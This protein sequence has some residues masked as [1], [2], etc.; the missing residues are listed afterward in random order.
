MSAQYL[1]SCSHKEG[2]VSVW[3]MY[4]S[5]CDEQ[6]EVFPFNRS[7]PMKTFLHEDVTSVI[8][9]PGRSN[10]F[11]SFS[12]ER[13]TVYILDIQARGEKSIRA[14]CKT[15]S[16]KGKGINKD[17]LLGIEFNAARPNRFFSYSEKGII[18]VLD[19]DS[20][21]ELKAVKHS[22]VSQVLWKP[23]SPNVFVSF[24]PKKGEIKVWDVRSKRKKPILT[25]RDRGSSFIEFVPGNS[26]QLLSYPDKEKKTETKF[27]DISG[28][29]VR[30]LKTFNE[31]IGGFIP[32]EPNR[33]YSYSANDCT[34]RIWDIRRLD[35]EVKTF[36]FCFPVGSITFNS[37][38]PHLFVTSFKKKGMILLWDI[39][40][41]D[42]Q[43]PKMYFDQFVI[44]F[45]A[46]KLFT[47]SY[48]KSFL[49]V[50]VYNIDTD[51]MGEIKTS[52]H[53]YADWDI[54]NSPEFSEV[55]ASCSEKEGMIDAWYVDDFDLKRFN[56]F[57]HCGVSSIAFQ[58]VEPEKRERIRLETT[59]SE[60]EQERIGFL[61]QRLKEG[62]RQGEEVHVIPAG[63]TVLKGFL[64][65]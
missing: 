43:E 36:K 11:A 38:R 51:C 42:N 44:A 33:Y 15:L 26:N 47:F 24:A 65:T 35:Q 17:L 27:W 29:K 60:D 62:V 37:E 7:R 59:V 3:D 40:K 28:K 46:K 12:R 63:V 30:L 1:A 25:F 61:S 58:S 22:G 55:F 14:F 8:A 56:V 4:A 19:M 9:N 53:K 10:I 21:R 49:D 64:S 57:R 23:R 48:Q 50:T 41:P 54:K 6:Q 31:H 39:R 45:H 2:T 20:A 32:G 16:P 13:G 5:D 34:M 18:K 52:F